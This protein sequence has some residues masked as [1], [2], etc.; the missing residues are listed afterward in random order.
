M[1]LPFTLP[2]WAPPW[3]G[4]V[5]LVVAGLFCLAFLLMPFSVFGL[6]GRLDAVEARLDEIQGEIRS[7]VL[8][9]PE[10]RRAEYEVEA[11]PPRR[12]TEQPNRPPI[13]PRTP[14]PPLRTSIRPQLTRFRPPPA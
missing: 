6:K 5:L 12:W 7:L 14:T 9:L 4:F 3:V 11:E 1:T 2:D 8:R 10:P 13:P